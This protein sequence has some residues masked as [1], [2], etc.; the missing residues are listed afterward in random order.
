MSKQILANDKDTGAEILLVEIQDLNAGTEQKW[1]VLH[2]DG[3]VIH[4]PINQIFVWEKL[5]KKV[6]RDLLN[7]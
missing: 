6:C 4:I 2:M 3:E 5:I 1:I 7:K